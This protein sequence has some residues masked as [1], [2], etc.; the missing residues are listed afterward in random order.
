[1]TER[2]QEKIRNLRNKL[3]AEQNGRCYHCHGPLPFFFQIGH[4]VPQ[5]KWCI[6]KWGADAIHHP[7]N[8]RGCCSLECNDAVQ[9]NPESK[10]AERL[11]ASIR[12]EIARGKK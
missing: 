1:M 4:V 11:M 10:E 9:I 7:R 6:E 5:R 3:A 2:E 8:T 12:A